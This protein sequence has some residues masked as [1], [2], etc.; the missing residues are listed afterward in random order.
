MESKAKPRTGRRGQ[1][2]VEAIGQID[3]RPVVYHDVLSPPFRI[4]GL[5]WRRTDAVT[6]WPFAR[7]PWSF[8]TDDVSAEALR[9]S[10]CEMAGGAIRFRSDSPYVSIRAILATNRDMNHMPRSGSAGFDLYQGPS[11]RAAH[12][13]TAQPGR[14]ERDF[15]RMLF[16]RGRSD[17]GMA[18][19][20]LDLPRFGSIDSLEI[21][22]A[23]E[24]TLETAIP[25][26]NGKILFY[27]SS[28]TQGA[29]ASRPGNA[30]TSLLCRDLDAEE[31]DL[32][33]AGWARGETAVAEA[34]AGLDLAAFVYDYDFNAPTPE[35]LWKTHGPFFQTIRKRQAG[36]PIVILSTCSFWRHRGDW[37]IDDKTERRRAVFETYRQAVEIG[38]GRVW[39]VD[40]ET[41]FGTRHRDACTVDGVHPNDLGFYRIYET[42]FPI[43]RNALETTREPEAIA[44]PAP[45]GW[46]PG[47]EGLESHL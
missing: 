20:T 28:V 5:P 29:C 38:D 34:I 40:G 35:H 33:F 31:I 43:L 12:C 24:A 47:Q 32:G 17:T 7:L 36:L 2:R 37:W 42:L 16:I 9:I 26:R 25:H 4:E 6:G 21:G 10:R 44:A 46:R 15:E 8:T 22:I 13:G 19:W 23:P 27:G 3:G 14:D 11:A 18:E 1:D 45:S 41:L 39:F 30:Y